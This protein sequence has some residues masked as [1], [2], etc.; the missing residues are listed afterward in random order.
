M[1]KIS[2]AFFEAAESRLQSEVGEV[3]GQKEKVMSSVV[4]RALIDFCRQSPDFAKAVVEGESFVDCMSAVAKGVGNSISDFD[5]Y[6]KAVRFYFPKAEIVMQLTIK[7]E[8][9]QPPET[10]KPMG[11]VLNL[12]D[13]I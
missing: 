4:M 6:K 5:A 7:T 11:I 1:L 8:T 9:E 12:Q 13:Y 2:N 10:K 3:K